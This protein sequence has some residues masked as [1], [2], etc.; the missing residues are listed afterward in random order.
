M[1]RNIVKPLPSYMK[2]LDTPEVS[3]HCS[4]LWGIC[5]LVMPRCPIDHD[6]LPWLCWLPS[7]RV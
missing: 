2:Q 1:K 5:L 3:V 4:G 7:S 6:C